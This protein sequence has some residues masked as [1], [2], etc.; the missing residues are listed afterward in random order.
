M[1]N[2]ID[3]RF[4]ALDFLH[5]VY[6]KLNGIFACSC[7]QILCVPIFGKYF[8]NS[9]LSTITGQKWWLIEVA[10]SN[11]FLIFL[12]R[13]LCFKNSNGTF[14][15]S[16]ATFLL[17]SMK[18]HRLNISYKEFCK[19][20]NIKRKFASFSVVIITFALRFFF[21]GEN[22]CTLLEVFVSRFTLKSLQSS[23]LKNFFA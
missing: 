3:A 22:D 6:G 13:Y 23:H 4:L 9:R 12:P 10:T 18:Y 11:P 15:L 1:S 14:H 5:T 20:W 8:T 7:Q 19:N 21:P 16:T 2:Q 17:A